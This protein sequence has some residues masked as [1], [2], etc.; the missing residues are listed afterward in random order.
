MNIV[1]MENLIYPIMQK[2]LNQYIQ[3]NNLEIENKT[4]ES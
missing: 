1:E 3:S 2:T 4:E